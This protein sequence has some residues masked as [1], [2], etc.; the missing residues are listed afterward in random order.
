MDSYGK[1][2]LPV[3][4]P[5]AEEAPGDPLLDVLL[6]FAKAVVNYQGGAAWQA[7]ANQ[8][9]QLPVQHV[10]AHDPVR[11][12]IVESQL[13]AL[14]LSRE[15]NE[16]SRWVAHDYWVRSSRL[17]MYWIPPR[18][19]QQQKRGR[20]AAFGNVIQSALD[21]VL[22]PVAR[23]PAWVVPGDTDPNAASLGSLV[24]KYIPVWEIDAGRA[25]WVD[26]RLPMA[27]ATADMGDVVYP[28]LRVYWILQERNEGI[29]AS[30]HAQL[31]GVEG[32]VYTGGDL[33]WTG[34]SLLAL[35]LASVAPASGPAAGGT[36]CTLLGA[37]FSG[38]PAV[39]FGGVAATGVDVVSP[40]MMTCT[41]PAHAV[42]AVDVAVTDQD[43][44][45][46]TLP[47]AY[48]YT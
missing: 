8:A 30:D 31:G 2:L 24:Y 7:V 34:L 14:F 19:A 1:L 27:A 37:G 15:Y 13:P 40:A 12:G 39:T 11:F 41:T 10:Y 48:T 32:T 42:G 9:A 47:G 17:I 35:S 36:A 26:L 43:G 29:L 46:A 16:P 6:D 44:T 22:D 4:V 20:I 5:G 45:V 3:P 33:A 28:A 38:A 18:V 21:A 25:E 23:T